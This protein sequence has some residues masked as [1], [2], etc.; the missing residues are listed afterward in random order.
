MKAYQ[1]V[2]CGPDATFMLEWLLEKEPNRRRIYGQ[3]LRLNFPE[4][5]EQTLEL[6]TDLFVTEHVPFVNRKVWLKR[7]TEVVALC[8]KLTQE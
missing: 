2:S 7:A 5:S 6:A 3:A 8:E 1:S 4:I